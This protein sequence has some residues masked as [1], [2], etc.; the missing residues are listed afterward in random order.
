VKE[1]SSGGQLFGERSRRRLLQQ[2]ALIEDALAYLLRR[3]PADDL[4]RLIDRRV[5]A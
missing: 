3:E 2:A 5:P 1:D 4:P